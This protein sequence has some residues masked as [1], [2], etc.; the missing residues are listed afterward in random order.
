MTPTAPM[1]MRMAMMLVALV[2]LAVHVDAQEVPDRTL[3]PGVVRPLS[4]ATI[5]HTKWGRDR[6][7]VTAARKKAVFQRYG[8]TGND[9][10]RCV[11]D[12]HGRRCEI[13]HVL[14]RE[15]GGADVVENLFP[16]A[17]G[18]QPWNAVRKDRLENRLHRELCAGRLT[19]PAARAL[20]MPDWRVG[21]RRY[22]G[23]PE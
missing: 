6:R 17:Y 11:P 14:S 20:L 19:L 22:F 15:L 9:D 4:V 16:Q 1:V 13:D 21:Y 5:C 7:H 18:S 10:P 2:L 3:T 8:Y 12:A 23:A